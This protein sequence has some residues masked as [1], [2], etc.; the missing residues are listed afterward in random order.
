M[1]HPV[2]FHKFGEPNSQVDDLQSIQI[3]YLQLKGWKFASQF[4]RWLFKAPEVLI[5][6]Y[7]QGCR[8][9]LPPSSSQ[10]ACMCAKRL[11]PLSG[12]FTSIILLWASLNLCRLAEAL[13]RWKLWI[14]MLLAGIIYEAN[15]ITWNEQKWG[16]H[17]GAASSKLRKVDNII[18]WCIWENLCS[19][20][21]FLYQ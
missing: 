20:W 2:I 18:D 3:K 8:E 11:L 17:V 1:L 9:L 19:N 4:L 10:T 16:G 15:I 12:W 7:V 5:N 21:L 14:K 6:V 13:K